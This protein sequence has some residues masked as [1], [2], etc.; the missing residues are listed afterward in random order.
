MEGLDYKLH[1]EVV[2]MV[3]VCVCTDTEGDAQIIFPAF[4]CAL[5]LLLCTGIKH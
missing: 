1:Q 3:R 2:E 5:S 4:L